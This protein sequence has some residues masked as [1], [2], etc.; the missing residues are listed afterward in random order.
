M[1]FFTP[2]GDQPSNDSNIPLEDD[3]HNNSDVDGVDLFPSPAPEN[4]CALAQPPPPPGDAPTALE[5]SDS[6]GENWLEQAK[7]K[8]LS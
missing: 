2:I 3:G 8:H 7:R 1:R 4:R 5:D 6:D